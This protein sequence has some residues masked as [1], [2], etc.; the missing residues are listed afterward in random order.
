VFITFVVLC[1]V[2]SVSSQH[3]GWKERLYDELFCVMAVKKLFL[4]FYSHH[5]FVFNFFIFTTF[6]IL[7]TLEKWHTY[8]IK[9]TN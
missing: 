3:T 7:K 2:S 6:F 5:I 1:L 9:A 8:I 4:R